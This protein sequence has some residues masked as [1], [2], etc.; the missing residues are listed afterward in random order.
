MR[1][2][3]RKTGVFI[4]VRVRLPQGS[5]EAFFI[6]HDRQHAAPT[7]CTRCGSRGSA[8]GDARPDTKDIVTTTK[9]RG[10]NP[11]PV[12]SDG[13]EDTHT[14]GRHT[15]R[16]SDDGMCVLPMADLSDGQGGISYI[17]YEKRPSPHIFVLDDVSGGSEEFTLTM[18]W[19]TGVFVEPGATWTSLRVRRGRPSGRLARD[20]GPAAEVGRGLVEALRHSARGAREDRPPARPDAR[21]L[22]RA[23]P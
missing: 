13:A 23:V 19:A 8:A 1:Y 16:R 5:P 14:F 9:R 11:Y 18:T 12:M 3:G 2:R 10:Y 6:D 21:V 7:A 20:G 4:T 22:G 17:K 15:R